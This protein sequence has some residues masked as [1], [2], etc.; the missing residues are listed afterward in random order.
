MRLTWACIGLFANSLS[1]FGIHARLSMYAHY[2]AHSHVTISHHIVQRTVHTFRGTEENS[3]ER[4]K[5]K[6]SKSNTTMNK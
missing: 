4:K 3:V 5:E 6:K 1:R 2:S